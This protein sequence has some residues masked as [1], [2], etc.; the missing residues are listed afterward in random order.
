M[1]QILGCQVWKFALVFDW[2]LNLK[3]VVL[4]L[5]LFLAPWEVS[6]HANFGKL[7]ECYFGKSVELYSMLITILMNFDRFLLNWLFRIFF[8]SCTMLIFK[9]KTL[10][11]LNYFYRANILKRIK[12]GIVLNFRCVNLKLRCQIYLVCVLNGVIMFHSWRKKHN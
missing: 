6:V 12:F 7:F 3:L 4:F 1:Y 11:M 2:P 9:I 10:T 5:E 8:K